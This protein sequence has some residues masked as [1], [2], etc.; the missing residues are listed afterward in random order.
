MCCIWSLNRNDSH[1]LCSDK[2][3]KIWSLYKLENHLV[4]SWHH[5][6][7][8]NFFQFHDGKVFFKESALFLGF[9]SQMKEHNIIHN[10]S[11]YWDPIHTSCHCRA[12]AMPNQIQS[13]VFRQKTI[14]CIWFGTAVVRHQHDVWIGPKFHIFNMHIS[15]NFYIKTQGC[16][17]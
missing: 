4:K 16:L 10:T 3:N 9:K 11:W 6:N 13:I 1:K 7:T 8:V 17:R 12:A 15:I 2:Q 5:H 14:A